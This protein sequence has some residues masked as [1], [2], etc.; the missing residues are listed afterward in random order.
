MIDFAHVIRTEDGKPDIGYQTGINNLIQFLEQFLDY[1]VDD[2]RKYLC[3]VFPLC[4]GQFPQFTKSP[5]TKKHKEKKKKKASKENGFSSSG[6][7]DGNSIISTVDKK[8]KT[9]R[10]LLTSPRFQ[11]HLK[12]VDY[13]GNN[14]SETEGFDITPKK[15][16]NKSNRYSLKMKNSSETVVEVEIKKHKQS[17][18]KLLEKKPVFQ[19]ILT[20]AED[21]DHI[22]ISPKKP[23]TEKIENQEKLFESM[24]KQKNKE[25]KNYHKDKGRRR[26]RGEKWVE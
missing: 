11:K 19:S 16:G 10:S 4:D 5:K 9:P 3:T 24:S 25:E 17:K 20:P 15:S 1:T 14:D 13:N 21:Q 7:N 23:T 2:Y 22:T 6:G 18:E 12:P 8:T 26:K